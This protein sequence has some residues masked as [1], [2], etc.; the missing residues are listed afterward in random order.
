LWNL[1]RKFTLPLALT[2]AEAGLTFRVI[3][4]GS[5][6][7]FVVADDYSLYEIA[8]LPENVLGQQRSIAGVGANV[9][10]NDVGSILNL[11]VNGGHIKQ[12]A[13][14]KGRTC[15]SVS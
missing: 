1:T 5:A 13:R 6:E 15:A 14:S 7:T 11:L 9:L 3:E 12:T 2:V 10:R 8:R 4:R